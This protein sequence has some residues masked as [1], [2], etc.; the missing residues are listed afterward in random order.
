MQAEREHPEVAPS[1][2][3]TGDL[4]RRGARVEDGGLTLMEERRRRT[5]DPLLG[6]DVVGRACGERRLIAL[7]L[8]RDRP[9][10]DTTERAGLLER[11]QI[12]PDR[13]LRDTRT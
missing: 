13:H 12:A 9:A 2:Q 7:A 10:V 1:P 11:L 3:C 5:A 6:L 8:G 4:E